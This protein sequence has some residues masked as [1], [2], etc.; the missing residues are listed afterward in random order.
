MTN[1]EAVSALCQ[2][3]MSVLFSN[4]DYLTSDLRYNFKPNKDHE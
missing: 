2:I 3:L 4:V 1:I